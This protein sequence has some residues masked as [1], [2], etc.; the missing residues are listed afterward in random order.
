MLKESFIH[1]AYQ[2]TEAVELITNIY[3]LA[4]GVAIERTPRDRPDIKAERPV[5][6]EITEC[7]PLEMQM[8]RQFW[9]RLQER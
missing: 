4:C 3:A 6:G 1:R 7:P 9:L 8:I 5:A 2:M